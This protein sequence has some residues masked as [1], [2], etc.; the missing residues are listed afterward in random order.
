MTGTWPAFGPVTGTWPGVRPV[1]GTWPAFGPG[2]E[3]GPPGAGAAPG[4]GI[5]LKADGGL[6]GSWRKPDPIG[7][8]STRPPAPGASGPAA[9]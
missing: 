7:F 9:S 6:P 1:T 8:G 4:T 5:V 3:P 2:L